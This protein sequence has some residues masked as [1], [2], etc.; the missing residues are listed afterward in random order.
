MMTPFCWVIG[1]AD[2]ENTASLSLATAEK[3]CGAP[4]GAEAER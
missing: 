3:F 4:E 2:Q 1:G